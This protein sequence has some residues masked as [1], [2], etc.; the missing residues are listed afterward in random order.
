MTAAGIQ[1]RS[2]ELAIL[3]SI[4]MTTKQIR[5][6]IVLEG[7][8]YAGISLVIASLS[9]IPLSYAVFSNLNTYGIPFSIPVIRNVV[10]F[11]VIII[12]CVTTPVLIF[13]SSHKNSVIERLRENES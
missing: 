12:I 11:L 2:K 8:S 10:L 6:M 7:G 3:E 4:G 13:N 5:K 1:N 9:G